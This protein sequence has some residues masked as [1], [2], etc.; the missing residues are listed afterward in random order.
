MATNPKIPRIPERKYPDD[1]AKV[2]II[3]KRRLPWVVLILAVSAVL[4]IGIV[5]YLPRF[6]R[7]T[8]AP[9]AA[10]VPPQP[11]N[12]QVQLTNLTMTPA[13]TGGAFYMQGMIHNDGHTAITGVRVRAAFDNKS[14]Q[15]LATQTSPLKAV[16]GPSGTQVEG[17]TKA[18]IQPGQSRR[19]RAYF[20]HYP[21]GWNHAMPGLAIVEVTGTT[22]SA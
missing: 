10:Q 11:T 16:T 12:R 2:Q 15:P 9:A 13:P 5:I 20:D 19:F 6:P 8:S 21:A 4:V 18:P 22:P 7:V 1:H 14:G 17:F 3:R